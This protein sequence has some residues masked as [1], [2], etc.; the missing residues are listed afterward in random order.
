MPVPT[1]P[2][3]VS[4]GGSAT[5]TT[6]MVAVAA[7]ALSAPVESGGEIM[8]RGGAGEE[9]VRLEIQRQRV[10][11]RVVIGVSDDRLGH[12]RV[13]EQGAVGRQVGQPERLHEI[14]VVG[15]AAVQRNRDRVRVWRDGA[16]G[17]W[18][19]FVAERGD[20]IRHRQVVVA[21]YRERQVFGGTRAERIGHLHL[22]GEL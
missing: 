1:K 12:R 8:E 11:K 2:L 17:I 5:G 18:R 14:A 9:G 4:T 19:V 21:V 15:V 22:I 10:A 16:G 3:S 7:V 13:E 6:S 20:G